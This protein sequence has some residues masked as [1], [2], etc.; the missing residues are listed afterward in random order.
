MLLKYWM[1][2]RQSLSTLEETKFHF[3]FATLQKT[4]IVLVRKMYCVNHL[5]TW[6]QSAVGH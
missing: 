4:V 6:Y 5:V 2:F 3:L 1:P